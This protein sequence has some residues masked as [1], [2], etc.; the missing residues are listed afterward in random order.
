MTILARAGLTAAALFAATP[1]LAHHPMGG[2]T[3]ATLFQGLASGVG[4]PIIGLDHLA[5]ILAAGAAAA[6]IGRALPLALAFAAA[7]VVGLVVH[8]NAVT[9]PLAEIV[10]AGSA[11]LAGLML[12]ARRTPGMAGWTVLFG[13]AGIAHAYAYA[14]AIIGAETTP[15]LAYAVGLAATQG[16]IVFAVAWGLRA[17]AGSS[18]SVGLPRATQAV[19]ALSLAVGCV[20][21]V[22]AV[23]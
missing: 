12:V 17:I 23:G 22:Q 4:H 8:L 2:E 14:E 19:G 11:A 16:A 1:A 6:L 18:T 15:L 20:F 10:I 9:L 13:L 7:T 5:F 3:P 21:L